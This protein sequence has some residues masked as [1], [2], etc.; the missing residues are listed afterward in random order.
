MDISGSLEAKNTK[1]SGADQV[2][3]RVT[4]QIGN[5]DVATS[6]SETSDISLDME[7]SSEKQQFTLATPGS[8]KLTTTMEDEQIDLFGNRVKIAGGANS[9]LLQFSR[10][11]GSLFVLVPGGNNRINVVTTMAETIIRTGNGSD[12]FIL[13]GAV[14]DEEDME[15]TFD[16]S[17]KN[18]GEAQSGMMGA[19][20]QHKLDISTE[21]GENTWHL[22][23]SGAPFY[24]EGG[25]GHDTFIRYT[26]TITD[27]DGNTKI[28][29][30]PHYNISSKGGNITKIGFPS[31]GGNR[32]P[33]VS[34]TQGTW[35][36]T[37]AGTWQFAKQT[38]GYQTGWMYRGGKWWYFNE[39]GIMQT[40][41]ILSGGR[42]YYLLPGEGSMLTGWQQ[43]D[44]VWYYFAPYDHVQYPAGSM[45]CQEQTP[46]GYSVD[47]NGRW[48]A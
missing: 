5:L 15:Y 10:I 9:A 22:W 34:G 26:F 36:L 45:F 47:E 33:V 17:G 6:E 40:G 7:S 32:R 25:T 29:A 13:G 20:N 1:L 16:Y 41:W 48:I 14:D 27:K 44:G 4:D 31:Y 24:L 21:G 30:T 3:V 23:M 19:G 43:I 28:F 42:W 2:N 38:G 18:G 37:E 46:D 12:T 8:V 39:E 11:P 35:I